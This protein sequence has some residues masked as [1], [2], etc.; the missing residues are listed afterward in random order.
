MSA[1]TQQT[2]VRGGKKGPLF[3]T[4]KSLAK[5][6]AALLVV[7]LELVS[8]QGVLI[9]RATIETDKL[10]P[11]IVLGVVASL[12]GCALAVLYV[13]SQPELWVFKWED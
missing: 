6:R 10:V 5:F 1:V 4:L 8:L 13:Y 2:A 9:V 3:K 12:A 11:F 7:A